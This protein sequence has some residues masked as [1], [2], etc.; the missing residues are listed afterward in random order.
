MYKTLISDVKA[1]IEEKTLQNN[2]IFVSGWSFSEKYGVAPIRCKYDGTVKAVTIK[3]RSDICDKFNRKNIILCGWSFE[4]PTNK[5]CDIQ[6]KLESEWNTFLSFNTF[7]IQENKVEPE[8][9]VEVKTNST[10]KLKNEIVMPQND[11]NLDNFIS[12]SLK[13]FKEKYPDIELTNTKN[14]V[15]N[16]N[17]NQ[18]NKANVVIIDNFYQ[19]PNSVRDISYRANL[20]STLTHLNTVFKPIFEKLLGTEIDNLDNY[21]SQNKFICTTSTDNI[22]INTSDNDYAAIVFLTPNAPINTGITLYRSKHTQKMTVSESEKAMVFKNGNQ[23]ITEFEPVDI[24]GNVF[25]R[26]VI[27]NT[28]LIHAISHNFGTTPENGRIVQMFVFNTKNPK[29]DTTKI[30]LNL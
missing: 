1:V 21:E 3:T 10:E 5:Y 20:P 11:T 2:S 23:D 17:V 16:L 25:N 28:R 18:N 14:F 26:L 19:Q 13:L 29:S 27:L 22:L 4:L 12:D 24:I 15:L 6:I 7:N 8:Q 9:L 30:E